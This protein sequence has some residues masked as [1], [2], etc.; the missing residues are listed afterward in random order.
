MPIEGVELTD[1]GLIDIHYR[2]FEHAQ[3]LSYWVCA[4]KDLILRSN[5][6]DLLLL[7]FSMTEA[8]V[9]LHRSGVIHRDISPGNYIVTDFSPGNDFGQ[10]KLSGHEICQTK[11]L[12]NNDYV[13]AIGTYGY[14]PPEQMN[15]QTVVDEGMDQH[16]LAL[17][18]AFVLSGGT[19]D[20]AVHSITEL[21]N[22][23]YEAIE[24]LYGRR[25]ARIIRKAIDPEPANRYHSVLQFRC[26]LTF[27][28]AE[29]FRKTQ[30]VTIEA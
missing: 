26:A 23:C 7:I 4:Y 15:T 21:P 19:F 30:P 9:A 12:L 5:L 16:A 29:H 8:V 1:I 28:L 22:K 24:Q 6:A 13:Y 27:A 14:A 17:T 3:E 18:L 10:I 2:F 20:A 25:V 11:G